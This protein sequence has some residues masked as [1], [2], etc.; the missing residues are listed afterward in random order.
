MFLYSICSRPWQGKGK[1]IL[2]EVICR[3]QIMMLNLVLKFRIQC[4]FSQINLFIKYAE[5]QI[6]LD[7][8][9]LKTGLHCS[10]D[11][12]TLH[13]WQIKYL[14]VWFW[15]LA[16]IFVYYF[17]LNDVSLSHSITIWYIIWSSKNPFSCQH[18]PSQVGL[19]RNSRT[20]SLIPDCLTVDNGRCWSKRGLAYLGEVLTGLSESLEVRREP[21][22]FPYSPHWFWSITHA[23]LLDWLPGWLAGPSWLDL[24]L[25]VCGV[26]RE[27]HPLNWTELSW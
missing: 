13:I 19:V 14:T 17:S 26:G 24:R 27:L 6:P 15:Y 8:K 9:T 18:K 23:C 3:W 2:A 5:W 21:L 10:D 1:L 22:H 25:V 12:V 7:T 11:T 4:E 20:D 16:V